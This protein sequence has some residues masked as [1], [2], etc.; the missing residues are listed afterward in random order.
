[1]MFKRLHEWKTARNRASGRAPAGPH[2]RWAA[3]IK[4][5]FAFGN[6]GSPGRW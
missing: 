6:F 3:S 4:S 2:W 1:M 5:G